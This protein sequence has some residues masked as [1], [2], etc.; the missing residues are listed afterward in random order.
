M[1]C[2]PGKLILHL[3]HLDLVSVLVLSSH[4]LHGGFASPAFPFVHRAGRCQAGIEMGVG[5]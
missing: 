3:L 4:V 5:S 1:A 2:M